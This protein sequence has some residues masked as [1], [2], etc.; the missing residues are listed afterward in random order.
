MKKIFAL[1]M[2]VVSFWLGQASAEEKK[3]P[4]VGQWAISAENSFVEVG[5]AFS[6]IGNAML[7]GSTQ[8]PGASL[9][10]YLGPKIQLT[11]GLFVYLLGGAYVDAGSSVIASAW[12]DYSPTEQDNFF[13]EVDYYTPYL[14]QSHAFYFYGTYTRS[15]EL[16]FSYGLAYEAMEYTRDG[17]FFES[18]AGPF[19]KL[20]NIKF[21][22][23]YDEMPSLVGDQ[24]LFRVNY[25][26]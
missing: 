16:N 25:S 4:L 11:D 2:I 13:G 26:F 17:K 21:W 3:T 18:A 15:T 19:L 5:D 20:D 1:V 6:M 10:T 14:E 9:Y 8:A 24:V 22:L 23:A 7:M 12:L